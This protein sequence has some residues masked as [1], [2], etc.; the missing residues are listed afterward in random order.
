MDFF[1]FFFKQMLPIC[2]SFSHNTTH[3]TRLQGTKL[4][5][6]KFARFSFLLSSAWTHRNA[7]QYN[8]HCKRRKQTKLRI[9][10]SLLGHLVVMKVELKTTSQN[11]LNMSACWSFSCFIKLLVLVPLV[12]AGL[13]R[14]VCFSFPCSSAS[15]QS[16][17]QQLSCCF[18]FTTCGCNS[19]MLF[20]IYK[21]QQ[22][23]ALQRVY[24]LTVKVCSDQKR[25]TRWTAQEYIQNQCKD[26]ITRDVTS[27]DPNLATHAIRIT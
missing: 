2:F 22:T 8:R 1:N 14:L 11:S 18:L 26:A 21:L 27:G 17:F 25:Q 19:F 5:G 7:T 16:S 12:S 15:K 23:G 24:Q 20:A 13:Q 10:H 3:F 9:K 6:I 4:D